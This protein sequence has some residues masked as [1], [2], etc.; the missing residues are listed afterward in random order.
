MAAPAEHAAA[1]ASV[2]FTPC[3][4]GIPRRVPAQAWGPDLLSEPLYRSGRASLC[5]APEISGDSIP[6]RAQDMGQRP[7]SE[8]FEHSWEYKF[9]AR[10]LK[11]GTIDVCSEYGSIRMQGIEGNEGRLVITMSDPFPSGDVAIRDTRLHTSVR[12]DTGGLRVAMWQETQGMSTFRS[13]MQKGSRPVAVNVVL[14]LP[15]TGVYQLRLVANHQRVTVRDVDV[16]GLIEGY[17]SPG[18]DLNVGLGG[19]LTMRLNN[20]TLKAD[21]RRDAGVDFQGGTTATFRPLASASVE[22]FLTKGDVTLSFVG[23]DVA[24]DVIANAKPGSATVDIG[25]TEASGVDPSGTYAR[26]VGYARAVRKVAV[27]ATTGG[28]SVVVRRTATPT[29]QR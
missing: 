21:W 28:G 29:K 3:L 8:G 15:R 19:P 27:R 5:K 25:P 2:S 4:G 22:S 7:R 23:S 18:A 9:H 26:S 10:M 12:A 24:L 11:G 16:R 20:E 14:E 17:L 1:A 13:M 6:T